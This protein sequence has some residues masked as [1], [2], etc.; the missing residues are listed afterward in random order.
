VLHHRQEDPG[1]AGGI[2]EDGE[3]VAAGDGVTRVKVGGVAVG[4][5]G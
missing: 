3:I 5:R 4:R 2:V 1:R